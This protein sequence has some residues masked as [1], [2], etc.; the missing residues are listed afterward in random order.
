MRAF[1]ILFYL[2]VTVLMGAVGDGLNEAGVQTWGHLFEAIEIAMLFFG[3]N[4]I[5][6]RNSTNARDIYVPPVCIF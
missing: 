3:Q 4:D 2:L 1:I 6:A 5:L